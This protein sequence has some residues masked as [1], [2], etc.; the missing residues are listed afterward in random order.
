MQ[1]PTYMPTQLNTNRPKIG[2]TKLYDVT[3]QHSIAQRSVRTT[4]TQR[5]SCQGM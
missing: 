4:E 1:V 2:H 5:D 3:V